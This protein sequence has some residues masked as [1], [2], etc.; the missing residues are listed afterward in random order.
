VKKYVS[1]NKK[2][3]DAKEA[4][5]RLLLENKFNDIRYTK[6]QQWHLLYLT[7]IAIAGITSLAFKVRPLQSCFRIF[8]LLGDVGIAIMGC[9]FIICYACRLDSYRK[10]KREYLQKLNHPEQNK[11]NGI[12]DSN[13][14]TISFCIVIVF[15]LIASLCSIL[16]KCF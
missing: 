13:V 1:G 14:F 5:L 11:I 2:S 3:S 12:E 16:I 6:Q 8:L 9:V 15:S 10:E 4:T 7:L